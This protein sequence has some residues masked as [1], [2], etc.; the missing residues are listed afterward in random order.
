MLG[1]LLLGGIIYW[2]VTIARDR[3]FDKR[4]KFAQKIVDLVDYDT[5]FRDH[6]LGSFAFDEAL[7]SS[8]KEA[9]VINGLDRGLASRLMIAM[10]ERLPKWVLM[11]AAAGLAGAPTQSSQSAIVYVD[12]I[13]QDFAS[14]RTSEIKRLL[15]SPAKSQNNENARR[16]RRR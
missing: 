15:V 5:V 2:I 16:R 14:D 11:S 1:I 9:E 10:S 6:Y 13:L 4:R 7:S 3:D 12:K 8:E